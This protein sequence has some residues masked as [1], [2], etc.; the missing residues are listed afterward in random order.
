MA[1]E[2][3]VYECP[4][5]QCALGTVGEPGYFTSGATL[6]QAVMLTGKP[7]DELN[8]GTDYGEGVCPNCGTLGTAVP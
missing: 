2:P 7:T 5:T 3:T 4:S 8:E 1:T 6:E